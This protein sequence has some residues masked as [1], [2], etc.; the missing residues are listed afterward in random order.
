MQRS[1]IIPIW[2]TIWLFSPLLQLG[3]GML[4]ITRRRRSCHT[5]IEAMH[6]NKSWSS[7]EQQQEGN[8]NFECSHQILDPFL[9][10][11]WIKNIQLCWPAIIPLAWK[12]YLLFLDFLLINLFYCIMHIRGKKKMFCTNQKN[13]TSRCFSKKYDHQTN[14][15]GWVETC[16]IHR[17]ESFIVSDVIC[18]Y[19][20]W[21]FSGAFILAA[22]WGSEDTNGSISGAC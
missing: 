19:F 13:L 14:I 10:F 8:L 1:T 4:S 9:P 2:R 20:S 17:F 6:L 16:N 11:I 22:I 7:G 12:C 18:S 15:A 3:A 21:E 5:G